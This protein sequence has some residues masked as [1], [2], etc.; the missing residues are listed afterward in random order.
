MVSQDNSCRYCFATHRVLLRM[1]GLREERI[2]QLEH[3]LVAADLE[4]RERLALDFARRVSRSNP[5]PSLAD[6]NE[7]REAGYT[8]G[9]IKEMTVVAAS[10]VAL[11]RVATL[12]ALPP[13]FWEQLPDR[14]YARALRPLAA[15]I[16]NRRVHRRPPVELGPPAPEGPFS[17]LVVALGDLPL[18][19]SLR[20]V[21]DEA[22]SSPIL[23]ARTKALDGT[24]QHE[25]LL[26]ARGVLRQRRAAALGQRLRQ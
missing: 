1:I 16:L 3:D 10:M 15:R 2:R 20:R 4:P 18:A 11:N 22:W 25:V 21:I 7:L 13:Q 23:S 14:W 9:A 12:P 26:A 6:L 8:D 24:Q 19:R 5:G 17:Q